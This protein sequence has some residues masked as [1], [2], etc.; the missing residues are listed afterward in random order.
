MKLVDVNILVHCHRRDSRDHAAVKAWMDALLD[1]DEPW[2]YSELVLSGFVRVVT[3]HR[4]FAEPST[5]EEALHF[6]EAVRS[7]EG[8]ISIAP[9]PR[10][11]GIFAALVR[12]SGARGSLVPD[13]YLAAMAIESGCEWITLDADFS[14]FPGLTWSRPSAAR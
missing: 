11:W 5:L 6:A 9:G 14:R 12:A 10:H 1:S 4:V 8:A 2:A 3:S 7:V 13:A